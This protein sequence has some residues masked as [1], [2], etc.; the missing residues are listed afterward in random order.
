MQG[1]SFPKGMLLG[2]ASA[3]TQI[4]G[5]DRNNSWY[6]WY[7]KGRIHDGS[8]PAVAN[9][10]YARWR[11][12]A[13][14]MAELGIETYRFG[15]EWSRIEPEQGRFEEAAYLVSCG[16]RPLLTLHHFTNPLWP[17]RISM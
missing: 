13:D 6:D 17:H 3:A 4:E 15:V 7:E 2:A 9:D 5:G 1:F 10:H 8:S 12:D 11:E 16:I 14:L